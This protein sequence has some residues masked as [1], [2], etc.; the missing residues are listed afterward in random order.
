MKSLK[1]EKKKKLKIISGRN[2]YFNVDIIQQLWSRVH[3]LVC[4]NIAGRFSMGR[5]KFKA[6]WTYKKKILEPVCERD[7]G[8]GSAAGFRRNGPFTGLASGHRPH[9]SVRSNSSLYKSPQ[10]VSAL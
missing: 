9:T 6:K 2:S 1:I 5:S 3:M 4:G 10:R 7:G 8:K